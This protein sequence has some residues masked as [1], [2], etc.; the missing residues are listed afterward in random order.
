LYQVNG[1]FGHFINTAQAG[2]QAFLPLGE[3]TI[4]FA[5]TPKEVTQEPFTLTPA[6]VTQCLEKAGWTLYT[7]DDCRYC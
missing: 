3:T 6:N 7:A 5:P 2:E 4:N 1:A